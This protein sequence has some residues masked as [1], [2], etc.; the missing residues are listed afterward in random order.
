M[1][2]LRDRQHGFDAGEG[3]R[4]ICL[5]RIKSAGRRQT[6]K[7]ALVHRARIDAA[8]EIG[9]VGKRFLAARRNDRFDGLRAH[10]FERGERVM[11]RVAVDGEFD[12][13]AVDRRRLDLD[14]EP[15]G[16][17]A[18][19]GQLVG[20]AHI[21][22]HGSGDELDRIVRLH[23]GGLVGHQRVGRGMALVEAVFGEAFEQVENRVRLIA[24]DAVPHRA[25]DKDRALLLH[26][27]SDFLAHRA[28][29]KIGLAQC[30]AGKQLRRL[31]HLF[32]VDDDAEGF[33]QDGLEF[34]MDVIRLFDAVLAQTISR[35]IR[36]RAGPIK[37]HQR[38]DVLEPVRTHVEQRPPHALTF[39]LEDADRFRAR[40][41]FV[42]FPVVERNGRQIERDAT[43]F[44]KIDRLAQNRERL[45]A[46]E[47]EFDQT[48]L[49]H[50]FHVELGHRHIGFRIAIKRYELGERPVA[51][52]NAS[53]VGRGVA[54]Q[55]FELDRDV[56]S[57]PHHRLGIARRLQLWL[58]LDRARERDR[59]GRI[60]RHEFAELI[61]LAVRHLQHAPDIAQHAARLQ[62]AEGDDLGDLLAAITLLHV[63]DHLV[64]AVLA[65]I[66]IEVRHR[67]AFGIEKALE[68]K[69]EA[70]RVEVRNRERVGNERT[71]ARAAAGADR[72]ALRLRPLDE[73]GDDQEIARIFHA[74]DHI[75]LEG[76]TLTV[77]LLDRAVGD[78]VQRDLALKPLLRALSQF[79]GFVHL[80]G[81]DGEARQNWLVGARTE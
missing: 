10:A 54:R 60:L 70:H 6:F 25:F 18:E 40:Q 63:A 78:A 81:A 33:L 51:N 44:Q 71:G 34:W 64:A 4:A 41:K 15:L 13:R 12:A 2:A 16:L 35:D 9:Q 36:H 26:L 8:G 22:R 75:E 19:F 48:R 73:V 1:R 80:L 46:E 59:I 24:R 57:A 62:R 30:E 21:E 76:E 39:Q 23:V 47:V 29:K 27:F 55:A 5:Q 17:G 79:R 37:C 3:P 31:H 61:D 50:P 52:H 67:H 20:I 14:P 28:A 77:V 58:V 68:Q 53:G 45:Q 72:N 32:L 7:H 65:E 56:E 74:R 49:L 38:D 66:D 69:S 11:D 42:G 43:R